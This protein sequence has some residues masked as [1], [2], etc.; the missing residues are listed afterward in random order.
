ML[1]RISLSML[2]CD[3]PVCLPRVEITSTCHHGQIIYVGLGDQS[4][5]FIFARQTPTELSTPEVYSFKALKLMQSLMNL[6]DK[7][8]A[9]HNCEEKPLGTQNY[10]IS[11]SS[12]S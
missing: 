2:D 12:P 10:L 1:T 7:G 11:I 8:R 3:L 6:W 5:V 9:N 4:Q